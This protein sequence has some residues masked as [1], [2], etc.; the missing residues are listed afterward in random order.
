MRHSDSRCDA[1]ASQRQQ[2]RMR[3]MRR[4]PLLVGL[5]DWSDSDGSQGSVDAAAPAGGDGRIGRTSTVLV[6]S[7]I[8]RLRRCG[9]LAI[10]ELVLVLVQVA[11]G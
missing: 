8:A 7:R 10:L 11:L 9:C 6:G 4:M 1:D 3:R 5:D 2:L